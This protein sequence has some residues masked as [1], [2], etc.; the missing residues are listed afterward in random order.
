MDSVINTVEALE[1]QVGARAGAVD[2]KVIDHL[3]AH[4]QRWLAVSPLVFAG[5]SDTQQIEVTVAGGRPGFTVALDASQLRIPRAALDDPHYAQVG[6]GA[7]LLFLIPGLGETLRVNGA[8]EAVS[9]DDIVIAVHECYAHCAKALL[10][11]AFWS[12]DEPVART[13]TDDLPGFLAVCRFMALATADTELHTDLSP[14]GDPA[15]LL[16]Q[17]D[18]TQLCFADRPGNRRTDSMRNMLVRPQAAIMLLAPGSAQVAVVR[19]RAHMTADEALRQQF[20]VQSKVPKV[21]T[22]L[23]SPH[24]VL[25]ESAALL[26]ARPWM[27][28]SAPEDIDPAAVFAAHVK[29]NKTGGLSAAIARGMVS[30][31]GLMRKGLDQD[32]KRNMY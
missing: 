9:D 25:R 27:T 11:S 6:R 3:D 10:R 17:G 26:W 21:V 5:F 23:E 16:M 20:E 2:L 12:S 14:K 18:S 19:G 1:S 28:A 29:L 32:Y 15:G 13:G 30:I 4:A 31:P 7:G 24:V 8:V 22:V